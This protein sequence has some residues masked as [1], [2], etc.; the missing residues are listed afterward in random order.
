MSDLDAFSTL[1][2]PLADALRKHGFSELTPVQQAVLAPDLVGKDLRISS[3]TGSGK[4][5][6][7][8]LVVG[9]LLID[10]PTQPNAPAS[11]C[12]RPR[13]LLVAPTRELA[14]QIGRELEWLY[15]ELKVGVCVVTGGT[16]VSGERRQLTRGPVVV[17]G[18]P[19]R[20][21]DHLAR[22]A[23]DLR[24]T[25]AV[26]LDEA[27]Q[28]LDLGFREAL[29][30]MLTAL[31]EGCRRHLVSATFPRQVLAL[32]AR[33]QKQA[34]T[35]TG[36][37]PG[38]EEQSDITHLAYLVHPRERYA[39]LV[40]VLLMAP[41]ERTLVFVRTRVDAA[42]VAARLVEDGFRAGALS[43]ELAQAERT[44]ALDAFRRGALA[45]MVCT[46]VASRG[47]DVPEISRVIHAELPSDP[48]SLTHRSGR[49]GRAGRKGTSIMLVGAHE[50]G[51]AEM[52]L[53][54]ARI[55]AQLLTAPSEEEVRTAADERL[56]DELA[57]EA[58]ALREEIAGSEE[59]DG[60]EAEAEAES[61]D[62][63]VLSPALQISAL[64]TRLIETVGAEQAIERLLARL[65]D[66]GPTAPL[67]LTPVPLKESR[68]P[69]RST[70][71]APQRRAP[72]QRRARH[73]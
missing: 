63:A 32:A 42:D 34:I 8:G 44:R 26:V 6:A 30:T 33:Y 45:I 3:R 38:E 51:S 72:P 55:H 2:A 67:E 41:E 28:M 56:F 46:D 16:S 62:A 73:A 35:V 52:L 19:G 70:T 17:V 18:T 37:A 58:G 27:D 50:R 12:A 36:I 43:G 25:E 13:V 1:P 4:T 31:P 53:V 47:I 57:R 48:E 54:R 21:C 71:R 49:T 14:A 9:P 5:V 64:T 22:G 29:E 23:L 7:L 69:T 59:V 61:D 10:R 66:Q 15:A 65:K 39:A 60:D 20:L 11:L 68:Y 24:D 40:N